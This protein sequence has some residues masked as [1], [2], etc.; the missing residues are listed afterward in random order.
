MLVSQPTMFTKS[1]ILL[2]SE[3]FN[4]YVIF[5]QTYLSPAHRISLNPRDKVLGLCGQTQPLP[6]TDFFTQ[7]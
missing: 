3:C 7:Q 2:T 6:L 5:L 1:K 4:R